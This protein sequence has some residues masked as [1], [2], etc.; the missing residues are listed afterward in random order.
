MKKVMEGMI[1]GEKEDDLNDWEATE[2]EYWRK[3]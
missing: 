1:K 3:E 2:S